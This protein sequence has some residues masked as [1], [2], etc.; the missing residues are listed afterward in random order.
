ML[1]P[2]PETPEMVTSLFKGNSTVIFFRL[3]SLHPFIQILNFESRFFVFFSIC[4][5]PFKYL[6]VNESDLIMFLKLPCTT[7]WPPL[8]PA[9]GPISIIWSADLMISS[10]C[11]TT[12]TVLPKSFNFLIILI[13][14]FVS[15]ECRPILGSSST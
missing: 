7:I 5:F 3:F 10:S 8:V 11:S 13:S 15:C 4:N 14:C 1:F 12:K 6:E 9:Y 2:E